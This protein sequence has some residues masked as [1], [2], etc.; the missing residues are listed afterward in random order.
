[1]AMQI[2]TNVLSLTAQRN[3]AAN[4][5]RLATSIERLSTGLRINRAGDDAAGLAISE[6]MSSQIRGQTVAQRNANDAISFAQTAEGALSVMGE[7]L[8]RMRELTVQSLNGMNTDGDRNALN[9]EIVQ[10]RQEI[11]RIAQD[12]TFNGRHIINGAMG[13]VNFQIGAERGDV[14]SFAGVDARASVIGDE[15]QTIR[16]AQT[17]PVVGP[18][19]PVNY[20]AGTY[21]DIFIEGVGV[22]LSNATSQRNILDAINAVSAQTGVTASTETRVDLGALDTTAGF[23][24]S[25]NGTD[26]AIGAGDTAQDVADR[27]NADDTLDVVAS[28][29]NAGNLVLSSPTSEDI[30]LDQGLVGAPPASSFVGLNATAGNQTFSST[31]T[32]TTSGS[33][34]IT[35]TGSDA[36][37][38]GFNPGTP[39]ATGSFAGT[40]G[41]TIDEVSIATYADAEVALDAIDGAID[42]VTSLRAELG[43]LQN[44]FENVV[45][46][47][48]VHRENL[49]AARSRILDADFAAETADLTRAQIL[50]Q[51]G[52]ASLAQ[53]NSAPQNILSLLQ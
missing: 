27:I 50:Q 38:L 14:L 18:T 13:T 40:E 46:V 24:L 28:L 23:T 39:G 17:G 32:L 22:D 49:E 26:V 47:I 42:D 19:T 45:E 30:V 51:A 34:P 20:N 1:M 52:L 48:A 36:D 25:V 8:Q 11:E 21:T 41:L 53:A 37:A 33:D 12:T 6:R 7:A 3:V 15:L 10:L 35:V 2:N 4:E 43:A 5:S 44:R 9:Q 29:S 31:I 16:L